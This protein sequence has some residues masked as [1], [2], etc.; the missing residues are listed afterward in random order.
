MASV[1]DE[2]SL[3]TS[4]SGSMGSRG[5]KF[6]DIGLNSDSGINDWGYGGLTKGIAVATRD[7]VRAGEALGSATT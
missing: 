6:D 7:A 2:L 5:G 4:T 1:P 3:I